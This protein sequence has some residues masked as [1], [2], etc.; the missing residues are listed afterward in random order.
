MLRDHVGPIV[1]AG[2]ALAPVRLDEAALGRAPPYR[3]ALAA[4]LRELDDQ[5]AGAVPER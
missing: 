2:P 4:A 1:R 3:A 5:A